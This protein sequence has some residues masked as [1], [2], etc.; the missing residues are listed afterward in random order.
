MHGRKGPRASD[1][2]A[3][4]GYFVLTNP[5]EVARNRDTIPVFQLSFYWSVGSLYKY[6]NVHAVWV[7]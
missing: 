1:G 5:T 2:A 6:R 3:H 7:G 4:I